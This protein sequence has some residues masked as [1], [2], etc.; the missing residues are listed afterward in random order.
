MNSKDGI[1]GFIIGDALGVPVEF[2]SRESLEKNPIKEMTGYGT[3]G[4]APGTFSDDSS[5]TLATIDSIVNHPEIDYEDM[6]SR[7]ADWYNNSA[8][9]TDGDTF[10]VGHTTAL[11]ISRHNEGKDALKCGGRHGH[12]NGN[13][14]LMRILPIAYLSN[15][16]MDTE[17]VKIIYNV[18]SLTHSHIRSKIAC[19][20]YCQIAC[21]LLNDKDISIKDGINKAIEYIL[22]FYKDDDGF[23]REEDNYKRIL[24]HEVYYLN[25]DDVKSSGYVIDTLEAVIWT[26][27]NTSSYKEAL[28]KAVNLGGD[29]DTIAGICG[30]IAGIYYGYDTIPDEWL[31]T[32]L[33]KDKILKLLEKF[34]NIIE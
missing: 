29:T 27:V 28:L 13:G 20:I 31:D 5:L 30:G 4:K 17:D 7:F 9:T 24:S 32:L 12:D 1:M 19:H 2:Q 21:I 3:Y 8:Y 26:L 16:K 25:I 18:S 22:E 33:C 14:S 23:K 34:D 15:K 10:D 11:A 6:M